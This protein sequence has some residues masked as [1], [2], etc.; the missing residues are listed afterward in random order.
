VVVI[1][2]VLLV[3]AARQVGVVRGMEVAT[4]GDSSVDKTT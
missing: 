2:T 3:L 4:R 1:T